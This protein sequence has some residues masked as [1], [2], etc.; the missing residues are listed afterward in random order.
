[1]DTLAGA[2]RPGQI[3]AIRDSPIISLGHHIGVFRHDAAGI[4]W[5]R[6]LPGASPRLKFVGAQVHIQAARIDVD[7]D[8]VALLKQ[9]NRAANGCF[10]RDMPDHQAARRPRKAPIGHQHH[11]ATQS[12]ADQR[13]RHLQHLLHTWATNRPLIA[14]DDHIAWL[15]RLLFDGLEGSVF[16]L[17]DARRSLE[18]ARLG[19]LELDY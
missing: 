3:R 15:D 7:V 12:L 16:A 19:A 4:M 11:R 13:R 17:E 10:W 6:R 1:M 9:T 18:G 5:R 14:N 2:G 8:D